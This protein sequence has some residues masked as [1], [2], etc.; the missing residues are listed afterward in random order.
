MKRIFPVITILIL[1]SLL[2]LIF[3]QWLWIK[4]AQDI[5]QQQLSA[6][7]NQATADAAE[8]LM[9]EKTFLTFPKKSDILFPQDKI[10]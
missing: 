9:Q 5:K 1:L 10:C 2:G 4:S 7:I 6:N 3:F 8:R